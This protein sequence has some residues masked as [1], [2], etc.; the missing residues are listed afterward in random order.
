MN[1]SGLAPASAV[2][3]LGKT[4]SIK[5]FTR[6]WFYPVQQNRFCWFGFVDPEITVSAVE[7]LLMTFFSQ[8]CGKKD[9]RN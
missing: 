5:S 3:H 7:L 2:Q 6:G 8:L 4:S 9:I 1:L